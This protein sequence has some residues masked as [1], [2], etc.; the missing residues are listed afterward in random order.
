M[1]MPLESPLKKISRMLMA[2]LTSNQRMSTKQNGSNISL[3]ELSSFSVPGLSP[4]LVATMTLQ[5]DPL[6]LQR[7]QL[8]IGVKAK[9]RAKPKQME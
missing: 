1:S 6:F 8:C 2:R 3:I 5:L 4:K 7:V 9:S